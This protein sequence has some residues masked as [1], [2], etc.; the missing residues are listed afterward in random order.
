MR[1]SVVVLRIS[2]QGLNYFRAEDGRAQMFE[3][4]I[5]FYFFT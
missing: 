5:L 3:N 2:S 4:D 1:I